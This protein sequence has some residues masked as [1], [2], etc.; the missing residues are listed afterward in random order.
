VEI[1]KEFQVLILLAARL[2]AW[3]PWL[4]VP[5]SRRV[6]LCEDE[7][8][9]RY[10]SAATHCCVACICRTAP[11]KNLG[12]GRNAVKCN[13]AF[14]QVFFARFTM[15]GTQVFYPRLNFTAVPYASTSV[16]P[17]VNSVAS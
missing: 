14:S 9:I 3:G 4:C 7:E 8:A 6:C 5:A 16:T 1:G 13:R 15:I 2:P 10:V 17:C 11:A 12:Q